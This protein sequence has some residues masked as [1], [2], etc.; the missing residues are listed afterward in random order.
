[1][2][3]SSLSLPLD[4]NTDAIVNRREAF[5]AATQREFVPSQ[6]PGQEGTKP[7]KYINVIPSCQGWILDLRLGRH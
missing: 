2:T 4:W 6:T 3:E 7:L 5:Y 1:M